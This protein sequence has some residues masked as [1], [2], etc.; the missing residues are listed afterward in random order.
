MV[1]IVITNQKGGVGKTTT[2]QNMAAFLSAKGKKVLAIDM[3][4]QANLTISFGIDITTVT[5][6]IGEVLLGS[7]ALDEAVLSKFD[8]LDIIPARPDL[9]QIMRRP[10]IAGHLKKYELL[11]LH[12]GNARAIEQRYE[13]VVIDTGPA[14]QSVLTTNGLA[15]ADYYLI[16]TKFDAL[17]VTGLKQLVDNIDKLR[18]DWLNRG[19][20]MAGILGTFYQK[21]R[22]CRQFEGIL[23]RSQFGKDLFATRIRRNVALP[24]S[25]AQGL[26]I[27]IFDKNS[28]GYQDYFNAT[29]ELLA[30][31]EGIAGA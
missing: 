23:E 26:P 5:N 6:T 30:R 18:H 16:P 27:T 13:Y 12:L 10:E 14:A 2:A 9:E 22:T 11:K 7:C 8:N 21:T 4:T 29:E 15:A 24:G 19:I 20:R 28:T 3:C 17:S 1:K 31:V 25:I